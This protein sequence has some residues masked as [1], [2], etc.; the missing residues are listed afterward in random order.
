MRD[1][2]AKGDREEFIE[3]FR[4]PAQPSVLEEAGAALLFLAAVIGTILV[5][6]NLW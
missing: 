4:P 6:F 5:I 3:E 1:D 2:R